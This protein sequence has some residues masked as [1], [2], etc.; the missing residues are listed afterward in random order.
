MGG[1]GSGRKPKQKKETIE[2]FKQAKETPKKKNGIMHVSRI[3]TSSGCR[4][5]G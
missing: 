1:K 2:D 5:G 3:K 4:F